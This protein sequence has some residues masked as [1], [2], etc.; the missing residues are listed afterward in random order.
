MTEPNDDA[1]DPM[2]MEMDE[3]P[4]PPAPPSVDDK[5]YELEISRDGN[6]WLGTMTQRGL[7]KAREAMTTVLAEHAQQGF[8]YGRVVPYVDVVY[9]YEIEPVV[10]EFGVA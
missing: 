10:R 3:P 9:H 1:L 7:R 6:M 4:M 5:V 8:F 2:E